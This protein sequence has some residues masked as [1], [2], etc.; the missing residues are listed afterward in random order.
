MSEAADKR[1]A[2]L[3]REVIAVQELLFGVLLTVAEPVEVDV[4]ELKEAIQAQDHMIDCSLDTDRKVVTCR[5]LEIRPDH[6]Q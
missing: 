4:D 3:E 2:E 5:I 1:I 6:G